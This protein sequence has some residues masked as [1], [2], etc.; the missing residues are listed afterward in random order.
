MCLLPEWFI[1]LVCSLHCSCDHA[2]FT[3]RQSHATVLPAMM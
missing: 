3:F 2:E 1:S